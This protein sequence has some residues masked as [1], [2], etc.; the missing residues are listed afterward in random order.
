MPPEQARRRP[1]VSRDSAWAAQDRQAPSE[2]LRFVSPPELAPPPGYSHVAEIE[3][4]AADAA[5]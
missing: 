5:P 2:T 4:D 1:L 3:I